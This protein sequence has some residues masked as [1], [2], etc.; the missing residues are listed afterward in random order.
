M[1]CKCIKPNIVDYKDLPFPTPLLPV[2]F[3]MTN[4]MINHVT[5]LRGAFDYYHLTHR[6]MDGHVRCEN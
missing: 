1:I 5:L 4:H 2:Y 6:I 3:L